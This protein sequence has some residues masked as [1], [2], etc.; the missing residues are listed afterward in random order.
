MV[1]LKMEDDSGDKGERIE[2]KDL[3]TVLKMPA[4]W[5]ISIVTFCTYVF[6]LSVYYFIPYATNILGVSVVI[7]ATLG[8]LK[9][10]MTPFSS[11]GGG[12]M[13][14][15]FGTVKVLFTSF[16]MIVIA[17]LRILVLPQNPKMLIPFGILYLIATSS[18]M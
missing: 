4:V 11:F 9:R 1:Y 14:D 7:G 6:T 10:Y 15:K 2:F 8:A 13:S 17:V 5:I 18:L 3:G 16:L 12:V